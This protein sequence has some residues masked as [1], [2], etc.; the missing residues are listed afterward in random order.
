MANKG[1]LIVGAGV[2][3]IGA[4]F[5]LSRRAE[6]AEFCCPIEPDVCFDTLEELVV[7]FTTEH[8]H[9]PIDILWE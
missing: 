7:H 5:L 8:P 3:V 4:I 1:A 6:A 2:I 9:E